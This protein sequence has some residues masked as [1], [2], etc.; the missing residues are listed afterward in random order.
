MKFEYNLMPST[1]AGIEAWK[2]VQA[3][4]DAELAPRQHRAVS[5]EVQ[6][7][8]E[9]ACKVICANMMGRHGWLIAPMYDNQLRGG[10]RY[11]SLARRPLELMVNTMEAIGLLQVARQGQRGDRRKANELL[12]T[13]SL[14][15][16]LGSCTTK[17][18]ALDAAT[19]IVVLKDRDVLDAESGPLARSRFVEY[20]DDSY[21]DQVRI[22]VRALNDYLPGR[23]VHPWHAGRETLRRYY[24]RGS[25]ELGGRFFGHF[26]QEI[27]KGERSFLR[28]DGQEVA[29]VDYK[30]MSARLLYAREGELAPTGDL[31]DFG[32]KYDR[33]G[34][35]K[36]FNALLCRSNAIRGFPRGARPLFRPSVKFSHVEADLY[37]RFPLLK[38]A[39]NRGLGLKLM[40]TESDILLTAMES[41][42]D[43]GYGFLPLHDAL[44][45]PAAESGRTQYLM[46]EAFHRVTGVRLPAGALP[47]VSPCSPGAEPIL[48]GI[49]LLEREPM[50]PLGASGQALEVEGN[51][52]GI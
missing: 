32:R 28:I 19:E 42:M 44:L 51:P 2:R 35:K 46:A 43:R 17:D 24:S 21:T 11:T 33:D 5:A 39:A 10:S 25:F 41:L 40:K 16:L 31:F 38:R 4:V 27:R 15:A 26:A 34:I 36:V 18:A 30:S 48:K 49:H 22:R 7:G 52:L 37:G 13:P 20:K 14:R 45:V 23:V 3:A 9:H 47:K 12:A 50:E 1:T 8:R 29:Q 6:R